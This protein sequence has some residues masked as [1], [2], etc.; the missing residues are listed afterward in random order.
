VLIPATFAL[1]LQLYAIF[2]LESGTWWEFRE[3][4]REKVG[5]LWSATETVTR[6]VMRGAGQNLH[7]HQD[8]G[9]DPTPGPVEWGEGWIRLGPWTGEEP[10]PLPLARGATGPGLAPDLA[11]WHVEDEETLI[12][13]AGEFHVFRCALRTPEQE[14]ILWIAPGVGVIRDT[15]GTPGEPPYLE[16]SLLRWSGARA[17]GT[18]RARP[19]DPP[20]TSEASR[21]RRLN[22]AG[23]GTSTQ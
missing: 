14:S 21:A 17:T 4:S 5:A 18:E 1:L 23:H 12:V 22:R 6:F 15:H 7:L 11:G 19:P 8:G 2:P 10:L 16:R 9:L 13:P 3:T 20:P